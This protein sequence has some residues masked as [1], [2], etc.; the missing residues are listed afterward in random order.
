MDFFSWHGAPCDPRWLVI[1][2]KAGTTPGIVSAIM[3]ALLDCA[4]HAEDRRSVKD[5]DTETYAAFG[6]L[7]EHTIECVLEELERAGLIDG[8]GRLPA[9]FFPPQERRP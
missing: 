6:G 1:A 9:E 4:N 5:F 2:R 7:D 3:W 8:D